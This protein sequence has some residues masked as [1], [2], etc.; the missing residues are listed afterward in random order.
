MFG[1]QINLS[2]TWLIKVSVL[3]LWLFIMDCVWPLDIRTW[4][5]KLKISK[6]LASKLLQG[7]FSLFWKNEY[8]R[9][10]QHRPM[11]YKLST[12]WKIGHKLRYTSYPT[13]NCVNWNDYYISHLLSS[14]VTSS[15]DIQC[16][17]FGQG[18][19]KTKIKVEVDSLDLPTS[20]QDNCYH[21]IE[22]RDYLSGTDGKL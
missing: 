2:C 4:I 9:S 13:W 15:S 3:Q 1:Y 22:V 17:I 16:I 6:T 8:P 11:P 18:P 12:F 21:Y 7:L 20:D 19:E 5:W 10:N 14:S